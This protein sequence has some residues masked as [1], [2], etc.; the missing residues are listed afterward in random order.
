LDLGANLMAA[1][2]Y[3]SAEV[4]QTYERARELC[5]AIGN[6][7]Q[8]FTVISG[9]NVY[10]ILRAKLKI[11]TELAL[12]AVELAEAAK[13][14]SLILEAY[15]MMAACTFWGGD[16]P[17]SRYYMDKTYE[18]YDPEKHRG[19]ILTYGQD[20]AVC[21]LANGGWLRWFQGYPEQAVT[22][23]DKSIALAEQIGHM[24]SLCFAQSFRN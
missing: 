10:Y 8:Y 14:S 13:D 5:R 2:G 18:V 17:N 4:F 22:V 24:F 20:S 3:G 6:T 11:A 7:P 16:F 15:R 12:Q 1:A 21:V 23:T 19:N 9:L